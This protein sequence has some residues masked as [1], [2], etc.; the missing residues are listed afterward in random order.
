MERRHSIRDDIGEHGGKNPSNSINQRKGDETMSTAQKFMNDMEQWGYIN[1]LYFGG[2][3]L[4]AGI[5]FAADTFGYLPQIGYSS[6]W[7]WIF[8]G[9]GLF[10]MIGNLIRQAS[11]SIINPSAFDYLFGVVL[12]AIGIGGF[13]SLYIALSLLLVL[14]GGVILYSVIFRTK[15]TSPKKEIPEMTFE[16]QTTQSAQPDFDMTSCMAMM[17]KTMSEHSEGC[18]CEEM[19]SQ[20]TSEEGIPDEWLKVMSQM[21]EVHCGPQEVAEKGA[22]A[23]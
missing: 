21:M 7:S 13:T 5:V 9:A 17:D 15:K 16:R 4:W 6:A 12:L 20:F 2:V 3:L 23:S 8:L 11:S 18:D 19:M 10:S 22:Q 14:V 1:A